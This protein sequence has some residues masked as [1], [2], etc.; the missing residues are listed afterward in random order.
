MRT[1]S[2][3]VGKD[4]APGLGKDAAPGLGKEVPPEPLGC[5]L[6]QDPLTHLLPRNTILDLPSTWTHP[7]DSSGA[8]HPDWNSGDIQADLNNFQPAHQMAPGELSSGSQSDPL[9]V[10]TNLSFYNYWILT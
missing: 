1:A 7:G 5:E 9:D 4:A 2:A 8:V 10:N 3:G 6:L